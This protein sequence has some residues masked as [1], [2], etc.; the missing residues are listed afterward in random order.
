[1]IQTHTNTHSHHELDRRESIKEVVR[2]I[3][4]GMGYKSRSSILLC[5]SS[6]SLLPYITHF[7]NLIIT[8]SWASKSNTDTM[9]RTTHH[10]F[11]SFYHSILFPS[12]LGDLKI[13]HFITRHRWKLVWGQWGL[14]FL[15]SVLHY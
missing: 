8:S 10:H 12:F 1:M 14:G 13:F 3:V 15:I 5:W 2:M 6:L 4:F 11:S 9:T 7:F